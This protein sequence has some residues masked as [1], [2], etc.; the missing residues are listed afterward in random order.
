[1]RLMDKDIVDCKTYWS[2][3][4]RNE[5]KTY[6]CKPFSDFCQSRLNEPFLSRIHNRVFYIILY[7]TSTAPKYSDMILF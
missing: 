6:E 7:L 5:W 2:K 3:S 1:M 4:G